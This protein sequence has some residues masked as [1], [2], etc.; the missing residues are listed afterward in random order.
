M[1]VIAGTL[2]AKLCQDNFKSKMVV[3]IFEELGKKFVNFSSVHL[4]DLSMVRRTTYHS[5][6]ALKN[7]SLKVHL[8][9]GQSDLKQ[10]GTK[11]KTPFS[12]IHSF[13]RFTVLYCQFAMVE[14]NLVF[15]SKFK[16]EK[17]LSNFF[18]ASIQQI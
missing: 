11:E 16:L 17:L 2:K 1:E 18:E 6:G 10:N 13:V 12:G 4:Q 7:F 14:A 8:S 3:Q 15:C 9:K 5:L